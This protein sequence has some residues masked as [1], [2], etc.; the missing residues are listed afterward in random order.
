MTEPAKVVVAFSTVQHHAIFAFVH[1]FAPVAE[2]EVIYIGWVR[3]VLQGLELMVL[4]AELRGILF[5]VFWHIKF[6]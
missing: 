2:K 3:K 4:R 5:Q 6:D 1:F